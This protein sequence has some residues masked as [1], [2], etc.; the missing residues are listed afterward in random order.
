[1]K[2]QITVPY[3]AFDTSPTMRK[4]RGCAAFIEV[5]GKCL[6]FDTGNDADIRPRNV[7]AKGIDRRTL[8]CVV[9]SR[10]HGGHRGGT[11]YLPRVDPM[12]R[13]E[14][15]HERHPLCTEGMRP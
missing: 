6:L 11:A 9:V 3:D 14:R 8:D 10:R 4:D 12:A 7:K 13:I 5:G 15:A 1:M 2:V